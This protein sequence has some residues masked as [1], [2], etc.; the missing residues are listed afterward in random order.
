MKKIKAPH[1]NRS[2]IV[3]VSTPGRHNFYY[4]PA[5]TRDRYWLAEYPFSGS[6]FAYFRDKGRN[7]H[8]RGFSLTIGQLYAFRDY[9]N[10]R[11]ARVMNSL[12]GQIDYVIRHRIPEKQTPV[13]IPLSIRSD[14]YAYEPVA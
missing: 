6:V 12:P 2:R 11:L 5:G 13:H 10:I 8:E 3:C 7:L 1:D 9:S 14:A 4:Q